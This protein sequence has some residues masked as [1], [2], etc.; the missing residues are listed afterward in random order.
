MSSGNFCFIWLMTHPEN[1]RCMR[2]ILTSN[3]KKNC[4]LNG[5]ARSF[6]FFWL[7]TFDIQIFDSH[8]AAVVSRLSCCCC[9]CCYWCC[10]ANNFIRFKRSLFFLYVWIHSQFHTNHIAL[11]RKHTQHTLISRSVE[12]M[13]QMMI[14]VNSTFTFS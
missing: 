9:Y 2:R 11:V 14:V 12:A 13:R 10:K 7:F 6:Y 8:L 3:V 5:T 1:E 4:F